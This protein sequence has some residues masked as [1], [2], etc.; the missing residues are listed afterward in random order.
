MDRSSSLPIRVSPSGVSVLLTVSLYLSYTPILLGFW[1]RD[2]RMR[3][4]AWLMSSRVLP[5]AVSIFSFLLVTV[6]F[7]FGRLLGDLTSWMQRV[8]SAGHAP[9]RWQSAVSHVCCRSHCLTEL[10]CHEHTKL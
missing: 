7:T 10:A 1:S 2:V 4:S 5:F 3:L 8:S 6:D 9:P